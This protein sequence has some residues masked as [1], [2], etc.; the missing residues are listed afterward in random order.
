MRIIIAD[1]QKRARRGLRA[2][3]SAALPSPSIWEAS[4]GLEAER[5]ASQVAPDVIIMD[6]HMPEVDGL[7]ATRH[8]KARQ[9]GIRIIALSLDTTMAAQAVAAGADCFVAK[10]ENLDLLLGILTGRTPPS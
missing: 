9:P 3:L 5:L 6:L 8:I 7:A 10:G 4:T 1:D 2:L